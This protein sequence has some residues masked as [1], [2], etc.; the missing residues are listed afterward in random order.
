MFIFIF[1]TQKI[2]ADHLHFEESTETPLLIDI[3]NANHGIKKLLTQYDGTKDIQR[4]NELKMSIQNKITNRH[5]NLIKLIERNPKLA[6]KAIPLLTLESHMNN[7]L[8]KL[9]AGLENKL[10]NKTANISGKLAIFGALIREELRKKYPGSEYHLALRSGEKYQVF[11]DESL[12]NSFNFKVGQEVKVPGI[13]I[14]GKNKL[15]PSFLI[16]SANFVALDGTINNTTV[17][18][19]NFLNVQGQQKVLAIL[20]NFQDINVTPTTVTETH[21]QIFLSTYSVAKYYDETS[22]GKISIVGD[23]VGWVSLP[24]NAQG[25]CDYNAWADAADVKVKTMGYDPALYSKRVYIWPRN[26]PITGISSSCAWS[27]LGGLNYPRS[28]VNLYVWDNYNS[29]TGVHTPYIHWSQ[30]INTVSHELG[31]N[32]GVHHASSMTCTMGRKQIDHSSQCEMLEYGDGSDVMGGGSKQMNAA[33]KAALGW[34]DSATQIQTISTS[35]SF[36]IS[37]SSFQDGKIKILRV[38]K[39]NTNEFYYIS[40]RSKTGLFDQNWSLTYSNP[41]YFSFENAFFK[42]KP[43]DRT[44]GIFVHTWSESP[45]EQTK[46]LSR[47]E[48]GDNGVFEDLVNKIFV[49][50][51]SHTDLEASVE[52]KF[53]DLPCQRFPPVASYHLNPPNT[54][55]FLNSNKNSKYDIYLKLFNNDTYNCLKTN[56]NLEV[57]S[58]LNWV[59]KTSLTSFGVAPQQSAII[60]LALSTASDAL[61]GSYNINA[62]FYSQSDLSLNYKSTGQTSIVTNDVTKPLAIENF[63]ISS[64]GG[65]LILSWSPVTDN[66]GAITKYSIEKTQLTNCTSSC[67]Q[68]I[69]S[70]TL[71]G[72]QYIDSSVLSGE[73]YRYRIRAEDSAYNYSPYS[74]YVEMSTMTPVDS[75]PPVVKITSPSAGS[76][77][78]SPQ[79]TLTWSESDNSSVY[80]SSRKVFIDGVPALGISDTNVINTPSLTLSNLDVYSDGP[81][82]VEVYVRDPQGNSSKDGIVLNFDSTIVP[83][84]LPPS[85]VII[86]SPVSGQ[87]LYGS[88]NFSANAADNVL[89]DHL[90][91]TIDGIVVYSAPYSS[92]SLLYNTFLLNDGTHTLTVKAVDTSGNEK[93]SAPVS[94]TVKNGTSGTPDTIAPTVTITSPSDGSTFSTR[95]TINASGSDNVGITSMSLYIDGVLISSQS[96]TGTS[97]FKVDTKKFA[98]GTKHTFVVKAYDKANNVGTSLAINLT[99]M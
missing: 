6:T 59:Q 66:Q 83:D 20:I 13:S 43:N 52:I 4:K 92:Y 86:N 50:Q 79:I 10:E 85:S 49:R 56:F 69:S 80:P 21:D 58:P 67:N 31:H 8:R 37:S 87:N 28:F 51:I 40:Y 22:F 39:P 73:T 88:Y 57:Q 72:N 1:S 64:S 41:Y 71:T 65:Q 3:E 14:P 84:T 18:F 29:T 38:R 2:M 12:L 7:S 68:Y 61:V 26:N 24:I 55:E 44:T 17:P 54:Q 78:T 77:V 35:G 27:G 75:T 30:N 97:S 62:I 93:V 63:K 42:A 48:M 16:A 15:S 47:V 94:F 45:Y 89:I 90:Q 70:I 11:I 34:L 36:T 74:N 53:G 95:L 25:I 76:T 9:G 5:E 91:F 19:S 81:H 33:H 46:L 99:K 32:F 98:K 96:S 23:T 82:L 60:P